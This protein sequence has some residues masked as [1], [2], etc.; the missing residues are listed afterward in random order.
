MYSV[1]KS[2]CIGFS[3]TNAVCF[4]DDTYY[5]FLFLYIYLYGFI[6]DRDNEGKREGKTCSKGSQV[7]LEPG[8]AALSFAAYAPL[9]IPVS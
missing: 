5:G 1:F 9:L 4:L 6:F 7:G 2:H 8:L 3:L